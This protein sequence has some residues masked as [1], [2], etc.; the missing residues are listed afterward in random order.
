AKFLWRGTRAAERLDWPNASAAGE[1]ALN[2]NES[3]ILR[4]GGR[5]GK[6]GAK[7]LE[8]IQRTHS[9]GAL[10]EGD[11]GTTVVLDGWGG[12][13]RDQGGAIFVD[14]RDRD[15]ITQVFFDREVSPP[16]HRQAE[17]LRREWVIGIR[18]KVRDR[19]AMRN[20]RL[21]T[22]AIE[23]MVSDLEVFNKSE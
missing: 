5:A 7:F 9:C 22:G 10:R 8:E 11:I 16:A 18:G 23:V 2:A 13:A 4:A 15:G 17:H 6:S 20:P 3:C 12:R 21:P 14:L 19:G 1:G